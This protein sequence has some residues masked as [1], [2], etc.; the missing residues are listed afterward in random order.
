MTR[1]RPFRLHRP[2][3]A[4]EAISLLREIGPDAV[5]YCG[6]TEL[7]LVAKL[8]FTAFTDLVDLKQV[9]ELSGISDADGLRIG[10]TTTHRQIEHSQTVRAGWPT[11]ALL[12]REVGN[13]RVRNVG[14]IGGNLAFADPH[15]DPATFL[16]AVGG[17]VTIV[18]ADATR[19]VPIE[20]FVIAPYMTVLGHGELLESVHIPSLD[21]GDSVVH[22]KMSFHERPAITVSVRVGVSDGAITRA[23]IAVGSV[24][25]RVMRAPAAERQLDGTQINGGEA[26]AIREAAATAADEIDASADANG[27]VEYKRQLVR[28]LTARALNDALSQTGSAPVSLM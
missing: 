2:T 7:L 5:P 27:S 21:P 26:S 10:A 14:T 25:P 17:Y 3:T 4:S 28:V 22:R 9:E 11:L 20:E 1:L 8:G 6:G 13:L 12:E 23:R 15:S 16:T 19:N 18:G 24:G